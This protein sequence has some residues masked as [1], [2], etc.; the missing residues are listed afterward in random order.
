MTE[1][2]ILHT[3][4]PRR[5]HR[6]T[7]TWSSGPAE[8]MAM[9]GKCWSLDLRSPSAS[10]T[11]DNYLNLTGSM[12]FINNTGS[13]EFINDKNCPNG[14]ACPWGTLYGALGISVHAF[15][16]EVIFGAPGAYTW[17]GTV[18]ARK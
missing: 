14:T 18:A 7:R 8:Y 1:A 11:H 16:N 13:K 2:D 5:Q 12:E 15:G 10:Q 4:A 9:Q 3:C 6:M 17:K